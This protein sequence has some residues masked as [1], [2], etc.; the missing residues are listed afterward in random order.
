MKSLL[1]IFLFLAIFPSCQD[2]ESGPPVTPSKQSE[3]DLVNPDNYCHDQKGWEQW[4]N[5]VKKFP[6]DM[7]LQALHA[8]R[9]G[10]CTKIEKGSI[11]LEDAIDIFDQAHKSVIEKARQRSKEK[12]PST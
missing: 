7:D 5:L 6:N 4:E 11:R 12:K 8:L 10:F 9:I 2:S 3:G 1:V